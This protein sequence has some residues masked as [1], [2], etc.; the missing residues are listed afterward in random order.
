MITTALLTVIYYALYLL[1]SVTILL[2][3]DVTAN[4][5]ITSSITT[6][7]SY[8]AFFNNI[9]PLDTVSLILTSALAIA[10]IVIGYKLVM[11][12]IKRLPAQS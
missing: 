3:P 8:Y 12:V 6:A 7:L 5:T 2:L 1:L 11:W 9:L 4:A 10:V